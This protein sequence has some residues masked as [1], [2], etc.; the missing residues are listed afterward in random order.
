MSHSLVGGLIGAG[1]AKAG[2]EALILQDFFHTKLFN[3]VLFIFVSP[4]VGLGL[5]LGLMV[6]TSWIVRRETP[7]RVDRWFRKLQ[8]LSAAAFSFGH[9]SNDAQKTMGIIVFLLSTT[10]LTLPVWLYDQTKSQY[11]PIWVVMICHFFIALGTLMGGWKVVRTLGI[12]V[13]KLQPIGGFCA[14]TAAAIT[15]MMTAKLG[16]PVSTTHTTSLR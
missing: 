7:R 3:T 13:T 11:V 10:K 15:L 12:R 1:L 8:L 5:G 2:L 9:G 16:I 4:V 14:E 6:M